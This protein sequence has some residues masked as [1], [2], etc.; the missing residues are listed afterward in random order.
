MSDLAKTIIRPKDLQIFPAT[1]E[2]GVFTIA[3]GVGDRRASFETDSPDLATAL[4]T[5]DQSADN[6]AFVLYLAENAGLAESEAEQIVKFLIDYSFGKPSPLTPAAID[7]TE[8]GWADALSVHRA[9]TDFRWIHDYSGNPVVMVRDYDNVNLPLEYG[10]PEPLVPQGARRV[11]L[12]DPVTLKQPFGPLFSGRRT[13]RSFSGTTANYD[14]IATIAA[15]TLRRQQSPFGRFV[16]HTYINDGPVVGFFL[17]DG[18]VMAHGAD[19]RFAAYMYVPEDHALAE[20]NSTDSLDAWSDLMWTQVFGNGAPFAFVLA[21][22]WRRYM[23]KYPVTRSFRWAQSEIGSFMHTAIM[24]G[25]ALGLRSFQSPAVEDS[26]MCTL[27]KSDPA[28]VLPSYLA[29]F[30]RR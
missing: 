25:T 7:W 13:M 18:E 10:L 28:L 8:L 24:V 17:I 27:L 19:H 22:D 11:K 23:W 6:E 14:D 5:F 9:T 15:W 29:T 1:P 16:S 20:L 21:V 4:M 3:W 2:P 12:P 26:A 30:G